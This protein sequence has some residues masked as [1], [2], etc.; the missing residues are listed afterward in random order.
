MIGYTDQNSE[1]SWEW[2]ST[3]T[4]N[5]ENWINGQPDN[6]RGLENHS[7]M[8]GQGTWND[9]QE[10]WWNLQVSTKKGDVKGLA[11]SPFIRRGDSAYVVVEGPSWEEAEANANK[12]GGNLV[13]INDAQENQWVLEN[14][15][16]P[17]NEDIWI[18]ISDK[19]VNDDFQWS[20]GEDVTFTDWAPGEPMTA[21]L[22]IME[23]SG[24]DWVNGKW[25]DAS[26]NDGGGHNGIAEIKLAP[27]NSPT[28]T[29]SIKGDGKVGETVTIDIRDIKD[30]DNFEGYTPNFNYSWE[31]SSDN[32]ETWNL[33]TSED[34]TD[35]NSSYLITDSEY[36]KHIR[37]VLSYMDGYGS[38]ES[39]VTKSLDIK[40]KKTYKPKTGYETQFEFTND[41]AWAALKEDGSVVAW[42]HPFKGGDTTLVKDELSSGVEKIFSNGEAFAAL[43]EDGSVVT[44]GG[45]GGDSSAI[46]DLISSD[47]INIYSTDEAFAALKKDGSVVT[48]G[49]NNAGGKSPADL[50]KSGVVKI[51]SNYEV[52][53]A[54]KDDGSVVV[55]GNENDN[56]DEIHGDAGNV[57]L[58]LKKD[59]TDIFATEHAFAALKENGSV[60]TWGMDDYGG[61]PEDTNDEFL[62]AL[63]SDVKEIHSFR[64]SFLAIKNDGSAFSWGDSYSSSSSIVAG[65]V[66]A[67]H[68]DYSGNILYEFEDGTFGISD[69]LRGRFKYMN[70]EIFEVEK[71]FSSNGWIFY[72]QKME[73]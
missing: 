71:I 42:G 62:Y 36:G 40:S 2:I 66:K 69:E 9:I 25:D 29:L 61:E 41:Y 16:D 7:V 23:N 72:Y 45:Y 17:Y 31:T 49:R 53:A 27:N 20:S 10:D 48:W 67:A 8:G 32:G 22:N 18:G 14:L 54:L 51:V 46:K 5:Y 63:S 52:F 50:L 65:P 1:G 15:K 33:L 19:D 26:I 68:S 73:Y 11:E 55:W 6:S 57:S 24:V 59:V 38:N 39:V 3:E 44:W 35:N 64:R 12:L 30:E 37:G 43:K 70:N 60:V 13:T 28:G 47:V 21:S 56:D 34:A 4:S 58:Y